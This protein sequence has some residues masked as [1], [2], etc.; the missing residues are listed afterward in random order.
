MPTAA[1]EKDEDVKGL[2]SEWDRL[3]AAQQQALLGYQNEVA[4]LKN[5][6]FVHSASLGN[7]QEKFKTFPRTLPPSSTI[8]SRE[9]RRKDWGD[10]ATG[11]RNDQSRRCGA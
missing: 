9:C 6:V 4:K 5:P 1:D 10:N 2:W 3:S 11:F 8:Q 7:L